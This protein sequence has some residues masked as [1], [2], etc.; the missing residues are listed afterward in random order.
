MKEIESKFTRVHGTKSTGGIDPTP[1]RTCL[2]GGT[3][4]PEAWRGSRGRSEG[5][6]AAGVE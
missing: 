2:A 1:S 4:D 5:K 6:R 3:A